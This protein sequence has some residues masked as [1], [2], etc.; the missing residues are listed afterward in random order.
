MAS[1]ALELY[2]A[3]G[4][5]RGQDPL[6]WILLAVPENSD[7]CTYYHVI[8][9]PTQG[10]NYQVQIQSNKRVNSNGI[11]TSEY[12]GTIAQSDINKLKASAQ[13][14]A[15]QFCQSWVVRVLEDIEGKGMVAQGTASSWYSR[16]EP[17]PNMQSA[18]STST[19]P[20]PA[21][22]SANGASN[23]VW[24][25]NAQRNRYWNG[26]EWIWEQQLAGCMYQPTIL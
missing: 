14:V 2:V 4:Q 24:D 15:P 26:A 5:R 23:W 18:Q 21:E 13:R 20:T 25:E 7:R 1:Q 3:F 22:T 11:S 19:D 6:H 9:G 12:V 10:I 8:G 16:M 17:N